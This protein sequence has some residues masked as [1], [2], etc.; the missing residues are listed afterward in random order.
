[1]ETAGEEYRAFVQA[2]NIFRSATRPKQGRIRGEQMLEAI[3]SLFLVPLIAV[4]V[5]FVLVEEDHI[6]AAHNGTKSGWMS[7]RM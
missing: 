1:M 4:V 5:A 6:H 3:L 7:G 2:G